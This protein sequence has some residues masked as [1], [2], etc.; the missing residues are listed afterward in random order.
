MRA[1][2]HAEVCDHGRSMRTGRSW[3]SA[4]WI[5]SILPF[6][7]WASA[8]AIEFP[9]FGSL[10]GLSLAGSARQEG[11]VLRLTPSQRDV[12]GAAWFRDKQAVGRGFESV[13]QFRLTEQGG[14]GRG[15]D[16]LA[17][18]LQNSGPSA[19]GA[20]GSGGGFALGGGSRDSGGNPG[21]PQSIA[22]FFDTFKNQEIGD[23]SNNFV[24]ISTAGT[25]KEMRWPPARLASTKKL[26]VNLKDRK[27]HTARILYQPPVLSVYLDDA[28]VLVSTVDL[29]TVTGPDGAAWA[30]FT[31]STGAGFENHDILSWSFS[32]PDADA[33]MVS[34]MVS[35]PRAECLPGRNLCTPEHAVVDESDDENGSAVFHIVLPGNLEWGASIPN[36]EGRP[37]IVSNAS[38]NVCHDV[39]TLGTAGCAGPE[40]LIQR[41]SDGRTWFSVSM[42]SANTPGR[43]GANEGYFEFEARIR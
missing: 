8:A 22:V 2:E 3:L 29:S 38:G 14:L 28:R 30:G 34:S 24:T 37:V 42:F 6:A 27:T 18:V 23:P 4:V 13:F 33:S 41:T 21:I 1:I 32:R 43:G 25:P 17:F 12:A 16:G 39:G 9:D 15:A 36:P 26:P 10:P 35:F 19:L 31:A 20:D 7:A 11:R 40:A 5:C